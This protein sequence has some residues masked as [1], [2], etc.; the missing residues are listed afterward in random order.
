MGILS[1]FLGWRERRTGSDGAA[2][3]RPATTAEID[4][5]LR[6]VLGGQGVVITDEHVRNFL[7]YANE[8]GI[9]LGLLHVAE[10]AGKL[11]LAALPI[12]SPGRTALMFASPPASRSQ[13]PVASRVI[14]TVCREAAHKNVQ[15]VQVLLD[16]SDDTSRRVYAGADFHPMAEL[17]YLQGSP[18]HDTA[19]PVLPPLFRWVSYSDAVHSHFVKT[20]A[21]SYCDSLD[22]PALNGVREMKDVIDGHKSSGIFDPRHWLLLCEGDR[23]VGVL[24][25]AST[26]HDGIMELIYTGLLPEARRRK[27]GE[28]LIRQAMALVVSEK[29]E[30]LSLAVDAKN[31][32]A[33]K[34]Y[35]R[36]GLSRILTKLAMMRRM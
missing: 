22:C 30:R 13:E 3:V 25:V 26:G 23:P 12:I 15:L 24:L 28:I 31:V 9:D 27:L 36:N 11:A 7:E 21:A 4:P 6:L 8:R 18:R 2:I 14:D 17:I 20:I 1:N 34:L 33:L 35:Y 32:P 5:A 10:Q 29:Q 16:P 19:P